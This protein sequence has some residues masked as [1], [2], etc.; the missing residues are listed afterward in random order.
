MKIDVDERLLVFL[1]F[2]KMLWLQDHPA[3][4]NHVPDS[5]IQ[6]ALLSALEKSGHAERVQM[7]NGRVRLVPTDAYLKT[8][9]R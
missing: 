2:Y 4:G 7:S 3:R 5:I 8:L 1:P 9:S 6:R